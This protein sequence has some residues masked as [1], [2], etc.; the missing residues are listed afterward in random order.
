M[1][2]VERRP[3]S[4]EELEYLIRGD[5]YIGRPPFVD[6]NAARETWEEHA[7]E[8]LA[9]R[10]SESSPTTYRPGCRPWAWW[11]FER[12]ESMPHCQGGRLDEL[13]QLDEAERSEAVRLARRQARTM[14]GEPPP[15]ALDPDLLAVWPMHLRL[16]DYTRGKMRLAD[17]IVRRRD[18]GTDSPAEQKAADATTAYASI[19]VARRQRR[20]AAGTGAESF[21]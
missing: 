17:W 7:D 3:L 1:E 2:R 12:G 21:R 16:Y 19:Q 5:V 15:A 14:N 6:A 18:E 4:P 9:C 8:V 10:S 13:G 20:G 11:R